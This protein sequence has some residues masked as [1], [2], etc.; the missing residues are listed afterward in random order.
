[1]KIGG[2]K[3]EMEVKESDKL[4]TFKGQ[5]PEGKANLKAWFTTK[6]KV[7]WGS[8]YVKIEKIMLNNE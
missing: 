8:Y 1:M 6:D 3:E 2:W 4:L 7:E 5:F